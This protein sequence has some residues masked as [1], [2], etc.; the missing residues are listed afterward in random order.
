M[1]WVIIISAVY[2]DMQGKLLFQLI[3]VFVVTQ[4][5]GIYV[6]NVLI[7]NNVSDITVAQFLNAY[8]DFFYAV[9]DDQVRDKMPDMRDVISGGKAYEN[10]QK[11]Q[12]KFLL[13]PEEIKDLCLN[14]SR[15]K[16]LER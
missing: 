7:Q 2:R 5:L 13:V 1:S 10:K 15:L 4:L 3:A 6:A 16:I 9:L 12:W 14:S 11:K 8:L